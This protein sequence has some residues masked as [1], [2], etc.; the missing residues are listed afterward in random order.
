[1]KKNAFRKDCNFLIQQ[2]KSTIKRMKTI[3]GTGIWF[4]GLRIP[5]PV[6][7]CM[8]YLQFLKPLYR[9]GYLMD[10]DMDK[11]KKKLV[12]VVSDIGLL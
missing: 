8:I 9:Y 6:Q 2:T 3:Y 11:K 1:M 4:F 12:S 7:K 5:I 10:V